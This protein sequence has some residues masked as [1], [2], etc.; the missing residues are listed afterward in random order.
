MSINVIIFKCVTFVEIGVYQRS[1]SNLDPIARLEPPEPEIFL[2]LSSPTSIL[3]EH[4]GG[5]RNSVHPVFQWNFPFYT[6][7]HVLVGPGRNSSMF[8]Q[9]WPRA[10]NSPWLE[11]L[12]AE[13]SNS[14][15]TEPL[16]V[17]IYHVKWFLDLGSK[18]LL[19]EDYCCNVY[20][21][22]P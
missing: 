20:K 21:K 16:D 7:L 5:L 14:G 13:V 22:F 19:E 3:A 15:A 12:N 10:K 17:V 9:V 6:D 8:P 11:P 4:S 2:N 1:Q 18:W